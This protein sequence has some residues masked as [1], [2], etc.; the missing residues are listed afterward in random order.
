MSVTIK[1][2][3]KLA[4][5]SH[6]TVSRALN[7]SPLI[8]RVTKDKI[9]QLASSLDYSPNFSAKSLVLDRSY[10]IGLFFS[11]IRTGTSSYFFHEA[12]LGVSDVIN[13]R[14]NLVVKGIEDYTD[15]TSIHRKS[16]DGIIVMSQS[17][18]DE[19]FISYVRSKGIPII[20]LNR[21]PETPQIGAIVSDDRNGAFQLVEYMIL[22]GHRHI[23]VIEG[24]AGFRSTVERRR[25][26]TEAMILHNVPILPDLKASGTYDFHSGYRAMKKL[27]ETTVRPTAVFSFNDDMAIGAIKAIVENGLHVPGDISVAGFDDNFISGFTTPALTTVKR[28]IDQISREGAIKLLQAIA[29]KSEYTDII[30]MN[31]ELVIRDS[32]KNIM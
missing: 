2:I 17:A 27:L 9:K 13:D 11:T 29:N 6:T 4:G 19:A 31:T 5:V 8:N 24:K 15:F 7:D 23:A 21:L 10:N 20:V 30:H 16:F 1:D 3:A 22:M 32:I 25:G 18:N 12:V 26:F 28:P 14:Y